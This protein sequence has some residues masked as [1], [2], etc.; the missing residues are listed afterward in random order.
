MTTDEIAELRK[1]TYNATVTSLQLP[2]EDLMI[3]R[4]RPD[5]GVQRGIICR[6]DCS[7]RGCPLNQRDRALPQPRFAPH[8]GLHHKIRN[9]NRSKPRNHGDPFQRSL[10]SSEACSRL[11][12]GEACLAKSFAFAFA[13]AFI[14]NLK[15]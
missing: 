8:Y 11:L 4:V 3:L 7:Q 12:F 6:D 14:S 1:K 5:S 15:I 2:N 9:V 10:W 13:F